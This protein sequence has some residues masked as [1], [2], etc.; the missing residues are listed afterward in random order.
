MKTLTP[1]WEQERETP[2]CLRTER[3]F[4]FDI[5]LSKYLSYSKTED[6]SLFFPYFFPFNFNL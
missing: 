1:K 2:L 5:S 6:P 3:V 4:Y